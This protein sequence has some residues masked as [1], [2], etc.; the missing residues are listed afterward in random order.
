M[1]EQAKQKFVEF[2]MVEQKVEQ[3]TQQLDQLEQQRQSLQNTLHALQELPSITPQQEVLIPLASGIY[4]KGQIHQTDSLLVQLGA[5]VTA[6]K[7]REETM[8]LVTQQQEQ[9]DTLEQQLTDFLMELS[10]KAD[11]IH[12]QMMAL[13]QQPSA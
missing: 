4:V 12:K 7:T 1:N 3:V 6:Q 2:K 13:Q 11:D 8:A 5:S 10:Q 9:L